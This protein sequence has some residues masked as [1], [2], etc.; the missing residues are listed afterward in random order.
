MN[1]MNMQS[2]GKTTVRSLRGNSGK[3]DKAILR[4]GAKI[5]TIKDR[6]NAGRIAND[7]RRDILDQGALS[8]E[9]MVADTPA[10]TLAG[11]AVKL[12]LAAEELVS[13]A[14]G[15]GFTTGE[16]NL[17]SALADVERMAGKRLGAPLQ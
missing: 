3:P 13:N 12:R 1:T 17:L 7:R 8:M 11:V 15:Q 9:N 14:D 5:Q 6:I 2:A 4:L 10:V 16:L